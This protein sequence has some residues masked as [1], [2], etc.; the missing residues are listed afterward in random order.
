LPN[1]ETVMSTSRT[2]SF[3]ARRANRAHLPVA[4]ALLSLGLAFAALPAKADR[5]TALCPGAFLQS[6]AQT[7]VQTTGAGTESA[8]LR[9]GRIV[10]TPGTS[11]DD[12]PDLAGAAVVNVSTPFSFPAPGGT[13][14]GVLQQ[15]VVNADNGTCD[16][17]WRVKLNPQSAPGVR[18]DRLRI[19]PFNHPANNLFADFR[20][21]LLPLGIG[22]TQVT[23][24]A[25]AG[26]TITFRFDPG[27]GPGE[28]SRRVF[29]DTQIDFVREVGKVQLRTDNGAK[30]PLLVTY[31]PFDD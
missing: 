25:V 6:A 17:Y 16:I 28:T 27:I 7:G 8:A 23:R 1:E 18:V 31:V 14:T 30:S 9:P 26:S 3:E 12:A 19:K 10:A 5:G 24:S 21:D 15:W 13:V 29:L 2:W 4:A 22:S 11:L 20:N